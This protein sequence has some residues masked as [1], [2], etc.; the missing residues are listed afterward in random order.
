MIYIKD[1]GSQ[2]NI[3]GEVANQIMLDNGYV[4]YNG[5]VPTIVEYQHYVLVGGVLTVV[6]D[7]EAYSEAVSQEIQLVLDAKA[8]EFRYDDMLSARAIGGLTLVG[9]ENAEEVAIHTQAV[10]LARWYLA[11]WGKATQIEQD[12]INLVITRPTVQEVIAQLPVYSA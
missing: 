3:A 6:D 1:N 8:K 2:V 11:C 5:T 10:S 9:G 12:V 7:N 4:Q